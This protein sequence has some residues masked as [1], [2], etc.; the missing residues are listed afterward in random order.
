MNNLEYLELKESLEIYEEK[1]NLV[2]Q[3]EIF[4]KKLDSCI[5]SPYDSADVLFS[6]NVASNRGDNKHH[7][8]QA[9]I[10]LIIGQTENEIEN[11]KKEM[12][13]LNI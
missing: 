3:K 8:N 5:G 10:R 9:C 4:V 1:Q 12:E 13:E 11:L 7:L 6:G 2:K